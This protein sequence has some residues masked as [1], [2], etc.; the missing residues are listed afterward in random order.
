LL[1]R[2]VKGA[3]LW[4]LILTSIFA[5]ATGVVKWQGFVSPP[6]SI[7]PTFLKLS[8][9][10]LF[11]FDVIPVIIV[12]FIMDFF[13]TI[14]TLI[15]VSSRAGLLKDNK[16][17]RASRALMADAVGTVGGA[18]LG[19]STVTSFIES[20][21]GVEEGSRTGLSAVTAGFLFL[22]AIFFA[23]FI[24]MVGGGYQFSAQNEIFLYPVTAPVLIIVSVLMMK[25]VVKIKWDDYSESIPGILTLVGIP[26]TYS[27][28][29][30]LAFGFISYTVLKLISGRW[31]DLN[32][33]MILITLVFL[34][35]FILI[36][37]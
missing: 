22:L 24:R 20:A 23:P 17:P 31:R 12:F 36:K 26:L 3:I 35:R 19:T 18:L 37:M 25:E 2:K 11:T 29:D 28:A 34:V 8:F 16:L 4:G 15:G 27:I 10:G 7:S 5:L 6:P 33:I 9:K 32:F 1:I 13:D 21:S 14:G 30:G